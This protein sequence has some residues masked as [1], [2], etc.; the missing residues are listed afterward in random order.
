[1]DL[2]HKCREERR[3]REWREI[4]EITGVPDEFPQIKPACPLLAQS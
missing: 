2:L 3:E 1:M 4:T